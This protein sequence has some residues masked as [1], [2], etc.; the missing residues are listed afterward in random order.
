MVGGFYLFLS[1]ERKK[2]PANGSEKE[3]QNVSYTQYSI[4]NRMI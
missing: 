2:L 3:Q 4:I 1:R